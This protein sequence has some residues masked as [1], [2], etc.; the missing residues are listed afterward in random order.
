MT[1]W[2]S[3]IVSWAALALGVALLGATLVFVD[4]GELRR[5]AARLGLA[6]PLALAASGLWHLVRTIAWAWCF[7]D[8]GRVPFWRLAR[9]RLAAEAFSFLTLRGIAGEPLKV[10]LLGGEV[11]PRAATAAVALE[12]LAY[13]VVTTA[14]VGVAAVAALVALPLS[15]G[16]FRVFR[17][18]AIASGLL[19]AATGFVLAG[20][21]TY[22]D[23]MAAA[24]DRSTGWRTRDRRVWRFIAA[25]ERQLLDLARGDRRRL[26]VV[27]AAEMA[28][29][30]LMALEAWIVLRAVGAPVAAAGAFAIETFTRVASFA[31]AFIPANLGALEA[32]SVA[33][34][35]AVGTTGGAALALARRVRGLFWAG[36]GLA[37]Y[38]RA[39]LWHD[40]L[41]SSAGSSA[42]RPASQADRTT[43][44][45]IAVDPSAASPSTTVA[46][47]TIAER[48]FRAAARAGYDRFLVW[49]PGQA[50][51][52]ARLARRAELDPRGLIVAGT[53]AEWLTAL[54]KIDA[55]AEVTIVGGGAIVSPDL[56]KA[57]LRVRSSD[58]TPADVAAGPEYPVS[59]VL[60]ARAARAADPET[61]R[62]WLGDRVGVE[63]PDGADVSEGRAMLA[64]RVAGAADAAR[65]DAVVRRSVYKPTDAQLARFNRRLSLPISLAFLP[66]PV[67]ANMISV[68][69]VAMGFYAAWLF[70]RGSYL[71]GVAAAALS[72]AA[73]ILDGCDGEIARLRHQESAF[74]CWL[75]TFGDYSYYIA[76]FAGLTVGAVRQTGWRAFYWIGSLALAGTLLSFAILIYLRRAITGGRPDRLHSVAKARYQTNSSPWSRLIWRV[77]FVAT[78]AA[79]P[80]GILAFALAGLLPAIVVLA[81]IGANIY[82]VSLVSRLGDLLGERLAPSA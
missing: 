3:K 56:L 51:L 68:A 35:A 72:L 57:A 60:R 34:V 61:V 12:R 63:L 32:S 25:V 39:R 9:I 74:G 23:R 29:Y 53:V 4:P 21:G 1:S 11:E 78:R 15:P 64:V 54:A 48:I 80:Y 30:A 5:T 8:R 31:S 17:A 14:I 38:P 49:A 6:L 59:G 2:R 7:A 28:C 10:L 82:W 20:R 19:V 70:S 24:I 33:A 41:G 81:A 36:A 42:E 46:G 71:T 16:W 69:L 79:M 65:A 67:T 45:Y 47:L 26:A 43:L 73:S 62:A 40:P 52:V 44:L 18:F 22:L 66:T 27:V 77:S 75:E 37:V 13:L 58:A 55:E 50:T 76:I